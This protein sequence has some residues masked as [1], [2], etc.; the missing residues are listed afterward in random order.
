MILSKSF[1]LDDF[2]RSATAKRLGIDNTPSPEVLERLK[3]LAGVLEYLEDA[4][5]ITLKISS[6][7]RSP[8]LNKAVGGVETSGHCKGYSVDLEADG[9][10]SEQLANKI[11]LT[12]VKFDQLIVEKAGSRTWVHF[13]NDPRFRRMLF[14][15]SK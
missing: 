12:G 10:T 8:A 11:F 1:T 14:K 13:S 4:L 9:M 7:Y 2:T 6:G 5:G 15:I 3:V